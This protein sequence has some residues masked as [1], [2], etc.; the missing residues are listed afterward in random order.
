MSETCSI[1]CI[2]I[3]AILG[4]VS[5]ATFQSGG[6]FV[7]IPRRWKLVRFAVI[8]QLHGKEFEQ[9][10]RICDCAYKT[11]NTIHMYA[12]YGWWVSFCVFV[13]LTI[14]PYSMHTVGYSAHCLH[15]IRCKSK[16]AASGN[17]LESGLNSVPFPVR[18]FVPIPIAIPDSVSDRTFAYRLSGVLTR[19]EKG[20]T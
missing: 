14:H 17:A 15:T 20:R 5:L 12:V 2:T 9:I 7:I 11:Y 8:Y 18:T 13:C 10:T 1:N 19:Q 16:S 4:Q 6:L 3:D